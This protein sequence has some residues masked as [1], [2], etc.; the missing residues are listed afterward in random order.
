MEGG[1]GIARLYL[2][3]GLAMM[4]ASALPREARPSTEHCL[5]K[6]ADLLDLELFQK[7]ELGHFPLESKIVFL[8]ALRESGQRVTITYSDS[9]QG[10]STQTGRISWISNNPYHPV[11]FIED[12]P[13]GFT[14]NNVLAIEPAAAS[15]THHPPTELKPLPA[16]GTAPT[17]TS[18][19]PPQPGGQSQIA[20]IQHFSNEQKAA[21]LED[22]RESGQTISITFD[23]HEKISLESGILE[24]VLLDHTPPIAYFK[25][26]P[27]GIQ[28]ERMIAVAYTGAPLKTVQV[29]PPTSPLAKAI[30]LLG[31]KTETLP[32]K[33]SKGS[34][35]QPFGPFLADGK[36]FDY[37]SLP[38]AAKRAAS[39]QTELF[40]GKGAKSQEDARRIAERYFTDG[41]HQSKGHGDIGLHWRSTDGSKTSG[42]SIHTESF[43][44][45][46][47][48][49]SYAG[50]FGLIFVTETEGMQLLN[51]AA[52]VTDI[53]RKTSMT[54][55]HEKE[56]LSRG[57]RDPKRIKAAVL[58]ERGKATRVWMNPNFQGAKPAAPSERVLG[59]RV[60]AAARRLMDPT[61]WAAKPGNPAPSIDAYGAPA[62]DAW[63]KSLAYVESVAHQRLP[64]LE[65]LGQLSRMA[66]G[67]QKLA[68]AAYY[69]N[70]LH[71][72]P[73]GLRSQFLAWATEGRYEEIERKFQIPPPHGKLR[74]F[75]VLPFNSPQMPEAS[76]RD[77]RLFT[78]GQLEALKANPHLKLVSAEL[79]PTG[80]Y[81]AEFSF[82]EGKDVPALAQGIFDQAGLEVQALKASRPTMPAPEYEAKAIGIA[83]RFY[84][85]LVSVHPLWDG[86]GRATKLARDWILLH[87]EV[88][89]PAFT[90][91]NDFELTAEQLAAELKRGIDETR[92]TSKD[93]K[94]G[95]TET[96]L[97]QYRDK[98]R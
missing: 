60:L 88:P 36:S 4:A 21:L 48:F 39:G 9:L 31:L 84:G 12:Q 6:A 58:I 63:V 35:G 15:E 47:D 79:T 10:T 34:S 65:D 17:Q 61:D 74:Q 38:D 89:P 72:V 16:P 13:Y 70:S 22:L 78:A 33:K 56:L 19:A 5:G 83:T 96:E 11:I 93:G 73:K 66:L 82:P 97:K 1:M 29:D 62:T 95:L 50:D 85:A 7:M 55:E 46:R 64:R 75:G 49:A 98:H 68:F 92:K 18:S 27:F 94:L 26:D 24:K 59:E 3:F 71:K 52:F 43:E 54:L 30:G 87:L 44:V 76:G 51:V 32:C 53:Q 28:L 42:F 40:F 57:G 77:G 37:D 69:R 23:N 90:P 14:A 45:A 20:K 86:N 25:G 41:V 91:A 81:R 67:G 8:K 80:K 2:W